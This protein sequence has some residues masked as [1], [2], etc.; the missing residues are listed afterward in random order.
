MLAV[1]LITFLYFDCGGNENKNPNQNMD[2][3]N[4]S[5]LTTGNPA[6]GFTYFKQV[7]SACHGLDGKGLPKL[8]KDLTTSQFVSEKSDAELMKFIETGRLASDPL[9]TT[10]VAMPP[11]GGN[12][13]FG[14]Q[15]IMDIVAY[16]RQI[17]Q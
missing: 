13:A 4:T 1:V 3:Q 10:G 2:S 9:N 6:R 15:Q 16:V 5:A 12:P 14:D 7:C 8:G 17:H 11:K